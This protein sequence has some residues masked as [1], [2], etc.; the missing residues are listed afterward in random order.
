MPRFLSEEEQTYIIAPRENGAPFCGD[1]GS[2]GAVNTGPGLAGRY[3]DDGWA[4]R[5]VR[6]G[7]RL[8]AE[9]KTQ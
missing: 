1:A 5:V 7:R 4:V 8:R 2:C 3:R 9:W 6:G